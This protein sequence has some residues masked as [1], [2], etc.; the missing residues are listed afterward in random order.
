MKQ[1]RPD[2]PLMLKQRV[3]YTA[4]RVSSNACS[5]L[6]KKPLKEPAPLL[7]KTESKVLL[8]CKALFCSWFHFSPSYAVQWAPCFHMKNYTHTTT[9]PRDNFW[10]FTGVWFSKNLGQNVSGVAI[11][12][13]S[14]RILPGVIRSEVGRPEGLWLT[15]GRPT[16]ERIT[17]CEIL[18]EWP[19]NF[20][21]FG[22]IFTW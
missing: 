19:S 12:G 18:S 20:G 6:L 11:S 5:A 3:V 8:M 9:R 1:V 13:H 4:I 22:K 15:T 17:P 14:E 16:L 7:H 10:G 2:F 21:S